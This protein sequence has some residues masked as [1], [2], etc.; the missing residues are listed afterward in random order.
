MIIH[1]NY[2]QQI[3]IK[4]NNSKIAYKIDFHF[5]SREQ[6]SQFI[7]M[8]S[9]QSSFT[10]QKNISIAYF[11]AQLKILLHTATSY[12]SFDSRRSNKA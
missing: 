4:I 8:S 2:N 6:N 9:N 12:S 11:W 5:P 1:E 3:I 7:R 10:K